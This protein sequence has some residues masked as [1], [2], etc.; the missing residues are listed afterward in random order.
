MIATSECRDR[1]RIFQNDGL[2]GVFEGVSALL[3]LA[4]AIDF[5]GGARDPFLVDRQRDETP[6]LRI[7]VFQYRASVGRF[8]TRRGMN[9]MEVVVTAVPRDDER[10]GPVRRN[11]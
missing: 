4:C 7:G 10:R 8:V 11:G 3:D 1:F 5:R 6:A 2:G 9:R